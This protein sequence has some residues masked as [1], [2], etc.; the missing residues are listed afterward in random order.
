M[1]RNDRPRCGERLTRRLPVFATFVLRVRA[2][3]LGREARFVTGRAPIF[4]LG[5]LRTLPLQSAC[6]G[7]AKLPMATI[8]AEQMRTNTLMGTPFLYNRPVYGALAS[9]TADRLEWGD[10]IF[11]QRFQK[12]LEQSDY[13]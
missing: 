8:T 6:A 9:Q 7:A 13:V 10:W 11:S 5:M 3:R 1:P 12:P 4:S 2:F